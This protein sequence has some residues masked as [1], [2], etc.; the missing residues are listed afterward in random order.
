MVKLSWL[1]KRGDKKGIYGTPLTIFPSL[2]NYTCEKNYTCG[3]QLG[4]S[5]IE[6]KI[7]QYF[8]SRF[9]KL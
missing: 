1:V 2:Q 7:A 3:S 6:K 4:V 9:A 5:E 8:Q